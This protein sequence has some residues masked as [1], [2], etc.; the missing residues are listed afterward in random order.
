MG[1]PNYRFIDVSMR[2]GNIFDLDLIGRMKNGGFHLFQYQ[3]TRSGSF[4]FS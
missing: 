1:D 2:T 4:D 3:F